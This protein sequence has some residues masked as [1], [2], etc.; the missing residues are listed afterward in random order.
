MHYRDY[1]RDYGR[2]SEHDGRDSPDEASEVEKPPR[3]SP[4]DKGG[5]DRESPSKLPDSWQSASSQKDPFDDVDTRK[6]QRE[7]RRH[8]RWERDVEKEDG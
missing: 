8:D 3:E 1:D 4:R 5:R 2:Y 6:E 7:K